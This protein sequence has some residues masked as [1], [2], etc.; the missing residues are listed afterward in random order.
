M[1][2]LLFLIGIHNFLETENSP[3][4][5]GKESLDERTTKLIRTS[6][7]ATDGEQPDMIFDPTV[8]FSLTEQPGFSSESSW[9]PEEVTQWATSPYFSDSFPDLDASEQP[10]FSSESSWHPEEVTQWATSPYF[11]DSFLDRDVS[12]QDAV[13]YLYVFTFIDVLCL[14]TDVRQIAIETTSKT[15]SS[16]RI[17]FPSQNASDMYFVLGPEEGRFFQLPASYQRP[18]TDD[19]GLLLNSTVVVTANDSVVVYAYQGCAS[20]I[21]RQASAFRVLER[22]RL[23]TDYW[24]LIHSRNKNAHLGIVAVEDNTAV[25][26]SFN[27]TNGNVEMREQDIMLDKYVTFYLVLPFDATGTHIT[28]NKKISVIVGVKS[29]ILPPGSSNSE[30]FCESLEPVS[31]WGRAFSVA[32]F[33]GPEERNDYIVKFMSAVNDNNVNWKQGPYENE[34]TLH[35][36][37]SKELVVTANMTDVLE[38]N[39]SKDIVVAQFA[40]KGKPAFTNPA[41]TFIPPHKDGIGDEIFFPIFDLSY[42]GNVSNYLSVWVPLIEQQSHLVSL[43]GICTDWQ[44]LGGHVSGWKIFKTSLKA[45]FHVLRIKKGFKVRAMVFSAAK[46][47]SFAHPVA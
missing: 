37:Q 16:G 38:I 18:H 27:H 25:V 21:G 44:I 11:S 6:C 15:G 43:D 40:T 17:F 3:I 28:S 24:V 22:Q 32:H 2:L 1:V 9:Y 45:G 5:Y 46:L 7:E 4:C 31:T 35:Q 36:G 8:E 41:M 47:R 12:G 23:G 19:S 34:T 29:I 20:G 14:N 39:S 33:L 26:I 30:P 10:G 42:K 13:Q